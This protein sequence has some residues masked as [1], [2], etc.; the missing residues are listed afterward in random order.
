MTT[1]ALTNP[2]QTAATTPADAET[3]TSGVSTITLGPATASQVFT[4]PFITALTP[5][6][7]NKRLELRLDDAFARRVAFFESVQL[8]D[9]SFVAHILPGMARRFFWGIH[10]S[11]LTAAPASL[12]SCPIGG[13]DAGAQYGTIA[14][15]GEL[16]PDHPF[17]RE[18]KAI[19]PGTPSP[20]LFFHYSGG[21]TGGTTDDIMI[22]VTVTV[23]CSGTAPVS[24]LSF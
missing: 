2:T 9:L 8:L 19:N 23:K 11:T 4:V 10:S 6:A 12:L 24:A 14:V 3:R 17:G 13:M 15:R 21:T 18:L 22:R 5:M 1:P 20:D 7:P 16:P